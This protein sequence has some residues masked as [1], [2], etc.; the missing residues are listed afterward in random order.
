MLVLEIKGWWTEYC[1]TAIT[2]TF[3]EIFQMFLLQTKRTEENVLF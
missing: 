3:E 1:E 2:E